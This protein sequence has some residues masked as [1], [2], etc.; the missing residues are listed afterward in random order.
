[1]KEI[2]VTE[3]NLKL[4]KLLTDLPDQIEYLKRPY[5]NSNYQRDICETLEWELE[6][7]KYDDYS[8]T[9]YAQAQDIHLK[10]IEAMKILITNLSIEPGTYIHDPKKEKYIKLTGS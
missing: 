5:G 4:I 9:Q 8:D 1:M 6:N 7:E 2:K 3:D 10:T